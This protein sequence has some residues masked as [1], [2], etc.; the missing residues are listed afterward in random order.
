MQKSART[1]FESLNSKLDEIKL[2]MTE[3]LNRDM[4][5]LTA[6]MDD[7]Q[8]KCDEA[9]SAAEA[10]NR[11]DATVVIKRL[12]TEPDDTNDQISAY[13][14]NLFTYM[15]IHNDIGI[16]GIK[17]L[18]ET[19][20]G[21]P[22]ILVTLSSKD[23]RHTVLKSKGELAESAMYSEVGIEPNKPAIQRI[24]ES[25]MR[26]IVKNS[27]KLV[28]RGG[29]IEEKPHK[30]EKTRTVNKTHKEEKPHENDEITRKNEDKPSNIT[31]E[32]SADTASVNK[33]KV[34][35]RILDK[36]NM[37]SNAAKQLISKDEHASKNPFLW[38]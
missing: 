18:K 11:I 29:H 8:V 33:Q 4:A 27:P 20:K 31:R 37:V 1:V 26:V 9:I 3:N 17:R 24:M 30:E 35:H 32:S 14:K 10:Q 21:Y 13:V 28:Y 6:R 16:V 34:R 12:M 36:A 38:G 15:G 22:P 7:L 19:G 2:E 25:N 23:D 5:K